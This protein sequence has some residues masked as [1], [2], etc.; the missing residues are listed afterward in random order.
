MSPTVVGDRRLWLLGNNVKLDDDRCCVRYT[1]LQSLQ[2]PPQ[3]VHV[4]AGD[5]FQ[6][7]CRRGTSVPPPV[8]LWYHA[9]SEFGSCRARV[10]PSER[11]AIG[12]DG[13]L[14]LLYA[15]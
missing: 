8:I 12:V 9:S 2:K 13:K 11:I 14:W 1:E 4:H 10:K 6:L 3:H 7:K 5:N 15:V